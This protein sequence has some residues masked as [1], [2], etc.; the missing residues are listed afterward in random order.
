MYIALTLES[1]YEARILSKSLYDPRL[2]ATPRKRVVYEPRA[3]SSARI[4]GFRTGHHAN[5]RSR[6]PHATHQYENL[7]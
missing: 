1:A 6:A 2:R 7:D 3:L 4:H 5:L